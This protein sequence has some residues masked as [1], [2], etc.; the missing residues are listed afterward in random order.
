MPRFDVERFRRL[1]RTRV[2]GQ[3]CHAFDVLA[4]T[5][6][7]LYA[8]GRQGEPEGTIVLADEQT[9][10][11]G[12]ADKVWISPPRRNLYVSVLLRPLIAPAQ[13]PLLSLLAAVA[14]VDTLRQEGAGL[15]H[16]VAQRRPHPAAQSGGDLDGD[17]NAPGCCPVRGGWHRRQRQHDR[18]RTLEDA[19]GIGGPACDIVAGVVGARDFPRGVASCPHGE[20]GGVV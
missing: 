20:P 17:G 7:F 1:L 18:R 2:L 14:L 6:T 16:Q 11:R 4:S 10:G 8:L 15:R 3:R 9:A 5:N 12:Q 13:A 19:S